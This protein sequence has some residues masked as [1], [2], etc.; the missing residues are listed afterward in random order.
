MI[1]TWYSIRN[2]LEAGEVEASNKFERFLAIVCSSYSCLDLW[3]RKANDKKRGFLSRKPVMQVRVMFMQEDESYTA[4][5]SWERDTER[6]RLW[7]TFT[8]T[9]QQIRSQI[10]GVLPSLSSLTQRKRH[11][12]YN[13]GALQ[14]F[15]G[16]GGLVFYDE[17]TGIVIVSG[18]FGE[19]VISGDGIDFDWNDLQWNFD[20]CTA[21]ASYDAGGGDI[22]V[23]QRLINN[24]NYNCDDFIVSPPGDPTGCCNLPRDCEALLLGG[25]DNVPELN[26]NGWTEL[27]CNRYGGSW[28]GPGTFCLPYN[29]TQVL[30]DCGNP[31]ADG[32]CF[33]GDCVDHEI[34]DGISAGECA[35][36]AAGRDFRHLLGGVSCTEQ[37]FL[38]FFECEEDPSDGFPVTITASIN[39]QAAGQ[40][41]GHNQ[42]S[43]GSWS[44]NI[45]TCQDGSGEYVYGLDEGFLTANGPRDNYIVCTIPQPADNPAGG[46]TNANGDGARHSGSVS[47]TYN[48][49]RFNEDADFI[50]YRTTSG[51]SYPFVVWQ[52]PRIANY[53]DPR[54]A[55]KDYWFW[56]SS[57]NMVADPDGFIQASYR[58]SDG[59]VSISYQNPVQGNATIGSTGLT[60]V[61][62][63]TSTTYLSSNPAENNTFVMNTTQGDPTEIVFTDLPIT[64]NMNN[65]VDFGGVGDLSRTEFLS[66]CG[67][68]ALQD[69][70]TW[71]GSR[72]SLEITGNL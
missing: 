54:G 37:D 8:G 4:T 10:L 40:T 67:T 22:E 44:G 25:E 29:W 12:E 59:T 24:V 17:D 7:Q 38:D 41:A 36:A 32:C 56:S 49:N 6:A 15:E 58:K 9:E 60:D 53:Q 51:V 1:P 11:G 5:E 28:A 45:D 68:S 52:T 69:T 63:A 35:T 64:F 47:V 66:D 70:V 57:V 30:A 23:C 50:R 26:Q 13:F 42:C 20:G 14:P 72:G 71:A 34:I 27:R 18:R 65:P 61:T 21:Q 19:I 16:Q 43:V 55:N 46:W 33:I 31:K 3:Y 48:L 62:G 2:R 39:Y